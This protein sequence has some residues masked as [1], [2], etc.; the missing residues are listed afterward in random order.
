MAIAT[1]RSGRRPAE[2]GFTLIEALVAL[3]VVAMVVINYIGI[4]TTALVDATRARNWRLAREIAEER[5]SE[6]AA[7]A[8][9][10]PPESGSTV[11][12][13]KYEGFAYKIVI[14]ASAVADIEAEVAQTAA[15][16]DSV[17]NERISWLREREDYRRASSR[18]QTAI[19][20]QDKQHEDINQKLA[21]KAPSATDFEEVAVAVYFPKLDPEY[22][23]EQEVLLIKS[24][25]STLAISGLTPDQASVLARSKGNNGAEGAG[26]AGAGGSGG[27]PSGSGGLPAGGS[28]GSSGGSKR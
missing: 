27:A 7:G 22:P 28:S 10:A 26:A 12:I 3:M 9:E 17:A 20:Y 18:G 24:R 14:G 6:L 4:R 25:V 23:G 13:D 2:T 21:E 16:D 5:M 8:R 19:E 11:P 15:G 1:E